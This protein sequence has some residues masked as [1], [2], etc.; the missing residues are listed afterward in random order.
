MK[1]EMTVVMHSYALRDLCRYM[2][3]DLIKTYF[4][5]CCTPACNKRAFFRYLQ[6]G[7]LYSLFTSHSSFDTI[8]RRWIGKGMIND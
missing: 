7:P 8:R 3:F 1:C 4:V 5:I 6:R 2:I